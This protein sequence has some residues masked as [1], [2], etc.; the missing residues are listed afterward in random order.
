MARGLYRF[1]EAE[2]TEHHTKAAVC[3]RVPSGIVCLLSALTI[4]NIGTQLPHQV[5]IAIPHK[6]RAPRLTTLPVRIVRFS[7]ASLTYGVEHT[8]FEGVPARVTSPARYDRGLLPLPSARGKG[9]CARGA[10]RRPPRAQGDLRRDLAGSRSLPRQVPR[11]PGHGGV[12]SMTA[13]QRHG[14]SPAKATKTLETATRQAS[15]LIQLPGGWDSYGA[16]PVS[17]DAA[18]AATTLLVQAA[19][20]VP[21]LAAPAVVPTVRGGL[22]L[23]WHRQG[24]DLEIEFEPDGSGSWFAEDRET[25]ETVERPLLGEDAALRRWLSRASA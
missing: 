17:S 4:H 20:A 22:Q 15:A 8:E 1:T 13:P 5:W 11:R 12:V 16:K 25:E 21:N 18:R 6:A 9:R 23:E 10:E 14:D 19:S 3:L 24:V 7:G 2:I